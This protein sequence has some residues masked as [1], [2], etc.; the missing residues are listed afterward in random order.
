[1]GRIAMDIAARSTAQISATAAHN[2]TRAGGEDSDANRDDDDAN[3]DDD[4]D[5]DDDDDLLVA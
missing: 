2:G 5:D 3:R 1:M 4:D